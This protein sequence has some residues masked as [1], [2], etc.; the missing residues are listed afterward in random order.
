MNQKETKRILSKCAWRHVPQM[1]D[2]LLG[3]TVHT[4]KHFRIL[5]L[6]D[7]E[8]PGFWYSEPLHHLKDIL[9]CTRD[10]VGACPICEHAS[11]RWKMS[12]Q[13]N[14]R[15]DREIAKHLFRR[16]RYMIN[17][18]NRF[19][20]TVEQERFGE[21]V[22]QRNVGISGG[23]KVESTETVHRCQVELPA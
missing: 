18:I 22:F 9:P 13:M 5:P 10:S 21:N 11:Y 7:K 14:S 3:S 15:F 12:E 23:Q 8:Q 1:R 19:S 17:V 6:I 2:E 16:E 4:Y 20:L